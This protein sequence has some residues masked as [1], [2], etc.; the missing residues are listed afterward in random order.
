MD[1]SGKE[2]CQA[3]GLPEASEEERRTTNK[4]KGERVMNAIRACRCAR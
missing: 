2:R 1:E 3:S 4:D